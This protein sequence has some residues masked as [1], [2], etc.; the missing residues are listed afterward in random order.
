[1]KEISDFI[2]VFLVCVC[3]RERT[4]CVCVCVCLFLLFF[5][6]VLGGV[7][8]ITCNANAKGSER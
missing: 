1:M 7:E 3:V 6:V 8:R 2:F 4:L 5:V